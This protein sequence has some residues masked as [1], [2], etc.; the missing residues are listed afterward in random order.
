MNT[1]TMEGLVGAN[2]NINLIDTPMRVYKEARRRG[3]KATMDRAMGYASEF[4]G[5]AEDYKAEADEGMKEE[6]E[7]AK[8]KEKQELEKII[9]KRREERK[10]LE[11]RIGDSGNDDT[12]T[13]EVSE[14]GKILLKDNIRRNPADF[15]KTDADTAEVPL[16]YTKDGEANVTGQGTKI[17]ISI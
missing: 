11:E 6:A 17:S 15:T 14:E 7:E 3:D 5:R 12:D 4:A 9:E 10:K 2:T 13:L 16:I 1:K 8:E